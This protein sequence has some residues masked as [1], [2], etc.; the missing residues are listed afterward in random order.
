MKLTNDYKQDY[1]MFWKDIVEK[2]GEVDLDQVKKELYDYH[3]L[4]REVTKVYSELTNSLFS[5]PHTRAELI[6]DTINDRMIDKEVAY[7]D[8]AAPAL[9]GVVCHPVSY[10]QDYFDIT[11]G[12]N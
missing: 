12:E 6:I 10:L 4:M 5:K 1:E 8:L 7:E 11:E 2:D 9:N 3:L